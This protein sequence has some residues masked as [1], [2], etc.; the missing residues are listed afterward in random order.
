M[1]TLLTL[2]GTVMC[3]GLLWAQSAVEIPDEPLARIQVLDEQRQPIRTA[4]VHVSA[5]VNRMRHMA[6]APAWQSVNARG[7]CVA[8]GE[9]SHRFR[10][11]EILAGTLPVELQVMVAAPGYVPLQFERA[12]NPRET[13]TVTLKPARSFELRLLTADGKPVDLRL[14]SD[15]YQEHRSSPLLIGSVDGKPV[16]ALGEQAAEETRG[17]GAPPLCLNFGVYPL[18]DGRYR[19]D[20]PQDFTGA[21]MLFVHH[22]DV[23]RYYLH[24]LKPDEWQSGTVEVR[25]PK[26]GA[27]V[28][29]VDLEAWRKAYKDLSWLYLGFIPQGGLEL[30]ALSYSEVIVRRR[31]SGVVVAER[32]VAPGAYQVSL[33]LW[34]KDTHQ[35]TLQVPEGGVARQKIAPKP[36]D[37]ADYRGAR[38]V[39]VQIQHPGGKS[40]AG[41]SYRVELTRGYGQ[42]RTLQEGKL[43]RNGAFVLSNLYE[44]PAGTDAFNAIGYRIY[45]NDKSAH[46]FMLTQGDGVR[47]LQITLAPQPGDPAINFKAVDV[48][49]GK[50]VELRTLRG[51]WVYL[52]FWATWCG[53]CQTAIEELKAFVEK[54]PDSWRKQVVVLTVS[55]DQDKDVV[56]PHL[57]RRGWDKFAL[58][59]WDEG[60][61]AAQQ[62]GVEGI[63]TAFLID[64]QGK[65]V[66]A[67]NPLTRQQ[68][69]LLRQIGS[70]GGAR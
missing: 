68:E 52:E 43:D 3:G 70:K 4:K 7:V 25:L 35:T 9:V 47:E 64:P 23:I 1:R 46:Y 5:T 37:V 6:T 59:A 32:N 63:P 33:E 45:V 60:Q 51:K 16:C 67:G 21:L 49:T 44:N 61:R 24:T 50:P 55:V 54:Q 65:V 13:I 18:G 36:F 41:A 15:L 34:G 62:Y 48:R 39:R 58:H 14:A 11:R 17:R 69:S 42:A 2:L 27:M 66:W 10:M 20:V 56:L 53:P 8:E 28:L 12:A 57:Q 29:Q 30:T 38:Q 40:L 19:V 22:S 31:F 26:P